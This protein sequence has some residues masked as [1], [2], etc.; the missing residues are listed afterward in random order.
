[1][2]RAPDV[3]V[4]RDDDSDGVDD[5]DDDQ[6]TSFWDHSTWKKISEYERV[7]PFWTEL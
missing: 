2:M 4:A 1:M 6:I 5:N 7:R 3:F